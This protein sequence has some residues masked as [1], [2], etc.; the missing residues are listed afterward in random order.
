M[1]LNK[2]FVLGNL[3]RDPESR[4]LPSGQSVVSFGVATNRFYV[5]KTGQRQQEVEYHNV[6]AFGKLA[7]TIANYLRKGSLILVEGRIKTRG[8]EDAS[9]SKKFKT[10]IIAERIQLGPKG[11]KAPSS[12]S[13]DSGQPQQKEDIPIIEDEGEIDVKDI[14][15]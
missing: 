2:V 11:Y 9:G 7:E 4:A 10:E 5:D 14:P 13:D 15:L 12:P 6:T 3:T 8:W 1:N